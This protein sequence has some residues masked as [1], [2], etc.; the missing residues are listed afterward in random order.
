MPRS[1][2]AMNTALMVLAGVPA[3]LEY[4]LF[5][6]VCPV[7]HP[8][9]LFSSSFPVLHRWLVDGC[10]VGVRAPLV[11]V[12]A[13]LF[14]NM[15][16]L[17]WLLS[18]VQNS[19]WLI[20]AYW[21]FIPVLLA[22]AYA[23]HPQAQTQS[24][25]SATSIAILYL[26][27]ARLL[28]SYFRRERWQVG[29]REDWRFSWIRSLVEPL[30]GSVGWKVA[31]LFIAYV[32]QH[33][34]IFGFTLPYYTIHTSKAPFGVFDVIA[35]VVC[36][37]GL[38]IA[39]LSDT[40]LH[41]FVTRNEARPEGQKVAVLE[42]GLWRYSRR[43]NYFGEIV[44]WTGVGMWSVACGKPS[45]LM[46]AALNAALLYGVT[47]MVEHRML[48]REDRR[49]AYQAYMKRVNRIIPWWRTADTSRAQAKKND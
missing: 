49:E 23:L 39:Y 26:W 47:Y 18:L 25:R 24:W 43:P 41:R 33:P 14:L 48:A 38:V 34:F 28:H 2:I 16:V 3:V 1:S 44:F 29:W 37:A 46:G 8:P 20:D 19:T 21:Q 9:R 5:L 22:H 40:A 36:L 30:L 32:S 15:D 11:L 13:L 4:Y 45:D 31:V 10:D 27:A 42:E 7:H 35:P 6:R 12:N 17:L